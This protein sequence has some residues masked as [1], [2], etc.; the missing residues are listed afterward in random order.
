MHSMCAKIYGVWC[1]CYRT[2]YEFMESVVC[3]IE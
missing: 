2:F 1:V 3:S